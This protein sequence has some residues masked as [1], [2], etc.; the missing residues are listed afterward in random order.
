[1]WNPRDSLTNAE[2]LMRSVM[3]SRLFRSCLFPCAISVRNDRKSSGGPHRFF[4]DLSTILEPSWTTG[5]KESWGS[6][7]RGAESGSASEKPNR[8]GDSG[9]FVCRRIQVMPLK[10]STGKTLP[11][12]DT[13]HTPRRNPPTRAFLASGPLFYRE[14]AGRSFREWTSDNDG[15]TF[16]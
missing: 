13:V 9:F 4:S 6:P 11:L 7:S 2:S 3:S 5:E 8:P 16:H 10:Y 15:W 14:P 12:L 1:M